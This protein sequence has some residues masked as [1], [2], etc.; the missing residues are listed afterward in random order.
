MMVNNSTNINKTFKQWWSTIPPVSTKQTI[1]SHI[2]SLST[3]KTVAYYVSGNQG[4]GLWQ[5]HKC[6]R[7]KLVNW[8]PNLICDNWISNDNTDI[9]KQYKKKLVQIPLHSKRSHTITRMNDNINIDSTIAGQWMLIVNWLLAKKVEFLVIYK[10][11]L[12]IQQ[13]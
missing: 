11:L 6:D 12:F 2:N 7:V 9:N 10:P 3:K 5:A 13:K 4:P 8:I 1:T